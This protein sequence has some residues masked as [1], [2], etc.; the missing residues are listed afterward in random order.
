M[1]DQQH[2]ERITAACNVLNEYVRE[3][4]AAGLKVKIRNDN[5]LH[6]CGDPA[7]ASFSPQVHRE[8]T[9]ET[10]DVSDTEE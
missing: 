2:L 5:L 4:V 1:T 6:R 8:I 10:A 9:L 7:V 3:A